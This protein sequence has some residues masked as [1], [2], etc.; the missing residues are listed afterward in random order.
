MSISVLSLYGYKQR[1]GYSSKDLCSHATI[2]TSGVQANV[3]YLGF[4]ST[5]PT[6]ED[7]FRIDS[8]IVQAE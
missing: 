4:S 7:I 3:S 8:N 6:D 1:E 2:T 5:L